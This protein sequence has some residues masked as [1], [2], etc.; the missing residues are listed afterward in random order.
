MRL[1]F[2][3]DEGLREALRD[4][5]AYDFAAKD[6][7]LKWIRKSRK[8]RT[9]YKN[10]CGSIEGARAGDNGCGVVEL[11]ICAIQEVNQVEERPLNRLQA[12]RGREKKKRRTKRGND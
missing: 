1:G 6:G 4:G 5:A 7:A 8:F 2:V 3:R 11:C 12:H 10:E 9:G